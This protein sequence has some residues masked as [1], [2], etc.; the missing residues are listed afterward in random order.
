MINYDEEIRNFKS[1]LDISAVEDAI[2]QS[3]LTDLKDIMIEILK[4]GAEEK[5]G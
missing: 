1:S 3:D 2:V 4:G 5:K